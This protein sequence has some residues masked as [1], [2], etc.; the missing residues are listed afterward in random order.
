M[1]ERLSAQLYFP[2]ESR[3]PV[4]SNHTDLVKFVSPQDKSFQTVVTRMGEEGIGE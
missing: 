3:H 4:K 2:K 1:V